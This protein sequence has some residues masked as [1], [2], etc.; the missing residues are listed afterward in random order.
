MY[1]SDPPH[2]VTRRVQIH[3]SLGYDWIK[4]KKSKIMK[5]LGK[6]VICLVGDKW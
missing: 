1:G 4:K 5:T 3:I 6:I 2:F